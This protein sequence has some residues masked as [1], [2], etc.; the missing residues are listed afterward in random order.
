MTPKRDETLELR[1]TRQN[2]E[3]SANDWRR[4]LLRGATVLVSLKFTPAD[5]RAAIQHGRRQEWT[6]ER[7]GDLPAL[8]FD[9]FTDKACQAEITESTLL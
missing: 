5:I 1:I 2:T 8:L 4:A 7:D 6:H 3:Y 9:T